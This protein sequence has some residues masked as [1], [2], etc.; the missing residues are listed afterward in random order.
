MLSQLLESS[1]RRPRRHYST[2]V[3][4]VGHAIA[5]SG[6]VA[7]ARPVL[8][9]DEPETLITW[10]PPAPRPAAPCA[11][12]ASRTR[13]GGNGEGRTTLPPVPDGTFR[14][15]DVDLPERATSPEVGVAI[16]GDEWRRGAVGERSAES[17]TGVGR[18][19]VDREVVPL[20]TNPL[21]RYP[22]E[23]RAARIEGKVLARFV[24]DT[25]GRV[26]MESVIVD[27]SPHPKFTDAVVDALRRARFQPA[28][29]RGRKVPQLVSQPFQ[30][31]LRE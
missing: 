24:V 1:P 8:K 10:H 7:A 23:L 31:V 9:T 20:A 17:E 22:A 14:Q 13:K 5:L 4:I 16:S 27:A 6:A 12:C 15:I 29:Y 3:S 19:V 21:P 26:R 18:A 25:T 11:E 2:L 30:F 28:E